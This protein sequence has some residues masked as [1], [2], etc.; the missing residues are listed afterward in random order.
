MDSERAGGNHRLAMRLRV[1]PPVTADADCRGCSRRAVLRGL[2]ATAAG[3]LAGCPSGDP[4]PAPDADPGTAVSVCGTGLCLD[5]DDPKNAALTAIDG[6]VVVKA[7][8]DTILVVRTSMTA[9][10]AVSDVCTHAGC[11]VRYEHVNKVLL[12]PCHGSRFA[13]SGAVLQGP[14]TRPLAKYQT[15]LD[16]SANLLTIS[17]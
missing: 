7:P 8:R 6:A 9:M 5:L 10:Q 1:L 2:A 15:Q 16:L 17:L 4:A 3:V 13:L 12:C 11:A 14:A